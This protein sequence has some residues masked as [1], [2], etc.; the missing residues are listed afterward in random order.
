MSK[1]STRLVRGVWIAACAGAVWGAVFLLATD[2]AAL[3]GFLALVLAAA[4]VVGVAIRL[5]RAPKGR[6][7]RQG[8]GPIG[9]AAE[10][11]QQLLTGR[12]PTAVVIERAFPEH[13]DKGS[14]G[15]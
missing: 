11:Y 14:S 10:Q 8:L 4:I 7:L 9:D 15:T 13:D 5:I 3:G 1:N 2:P 6:R 12:E